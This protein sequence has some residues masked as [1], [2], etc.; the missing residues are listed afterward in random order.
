LVNVTE[1]GLHIDYRKLLHR[2]GNKRKKNGTEHG[3][4]FRKIYQN[5]EQASGQCAMQK[6]AS[7]MII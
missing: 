1:K 4:G 7:Y 6:K 3:P 2:K 5:R